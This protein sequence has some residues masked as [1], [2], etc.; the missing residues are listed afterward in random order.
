MAQINS[1]KF[2][3]TLVKIKYDNED[4]VLYK[5][6][7]EHLWWAWQSHT[8][9]THTHKYTIAESMP[10]MWK[11]VC[12]VHISIQLCDHSWYSFIKNIQLFLHAYSR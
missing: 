5:R 3:S 6:I 2:R 8:A 10:N 12:T 4:V 9:H 7:N 11:V 1:L